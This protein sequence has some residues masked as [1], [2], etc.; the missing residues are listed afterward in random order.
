MTV[1][2]CTISVWASSL[3]AITSDGLSPIDIN[4]WSGGD[5][6]RTISRKVG[7]LEFVDEIT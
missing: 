6:F 2:K 4:S 5:M 7:V 3:V 1:I